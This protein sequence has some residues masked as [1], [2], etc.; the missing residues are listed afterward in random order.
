MAER[1]RGRVLIIDDVKNVGLSLKRLLSPRHE[2]TT[3]LGGREALEAVAAGERWEVILLD[4]TMPEMSGMEFVEAVRAAAPE[5]LPR[6]MLMSGGAY[7]P[8][9]EVFLRGWPYAQL[10]KPAS[11]Q[12][13]IEEVAVA[14]ERALSSG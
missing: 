7:T 11:P 8:E 10:E 12:R 13:L 5:L 1:P 9:A 4:L 6:I 14:V 3:M 2:V